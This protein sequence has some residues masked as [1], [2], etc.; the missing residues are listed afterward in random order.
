MSLDLLKQ[1]LT[2]VL[3]HSQKIENPKVDE[4]FNK[5]K[6][7]KSYFIKQ[8][9]NGELIYEHP[10]KVS[11]ALDEHTKEQRYIEFIEEVVTLGN[12]DWDNDFISFLTFVGYKDFYNNCMSRD[13]QSG[14]KTILKNSKIIKAFKHFI[15]EEKLLHEIQNKASMIIQED[16]IEGHLC[17]SVHPLDFL[18]SSENLHNWRSCHSLDGDYR[19]GN[20][21]YMCDKST[22]IIYLRSEDQIVL[23]HF[24][25]SIPW[26]NKKWRCLLHFNTEY[27]AIFAG[28][29][30]PF[31]SPEALDIVHRILTSKLL[32]KVQGWFRNL[33]WSYWHNDQITNFSYENNKDNEYSNIDDC[34]LYIVIN[35]HI[36]NLY[37]IIKDNHAEELPSLHYNDLTRSSVYMKPYY[38]FLKTR[39]N[40]EL[41]FEIGSDVKCI[42]CGEHYISSFDTMM[43]VECEVEYG[44]SANTEEYPVCDC[45]GHRIYY[46]NG[47]H[48]EDSFVCPNCLET[49]TFVCEKCGERYFN[50]N[51]HYDKKFDQFVCSDCFYGG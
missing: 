4:I 24:P 41:K 42:Y 38:M 16:K 39:P 30:Y 35:R 22:M 48:I 6:E 9:F 50:S 1:R 34:A 12:Y 36:H 21:S 3:S 23:P 27:N 43:C 11:F 5:W 31:S 45:C 33:E 51:K 14:E 28:R 10:E 29:Q 49:E 19:A 26:N 46:R 18:S 47:T 20:L 17:F 40:S 32:P 2:E 7:S 13:Y 44:N 8:C 25:D 37:S 15:T